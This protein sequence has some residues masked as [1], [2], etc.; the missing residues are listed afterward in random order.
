MTGERQAEKRNKNKKTNED[1]RR[2]EMKMKNNLLAG[3]ALMM[4]AFSFNEAQA[5]SCAVPPTCAQL[6]YVLKADD[7]KGFYMMRCPFALTDDNQVFCHHALKRE[8]VTGKILYGDGT[9]SKELISG[10]TPIG[11][12]FDETN[13]LAVALTDVKKDGS[14]G[15]EGMLWAGGKTRYDIPNLENCAMRGSGSTEFDLT[16][17][18]SCTPDGRANTDKILACGDACGGTPAATACNLYK[19]SG[20]SAAFCGQGKWFLPS[21]KEFSKIFE[22]KAVIDDTLTFLQEYGATKFSSS[23]WGSNERSESE[24]WWVY[25]IA[26]NTSLK[27]ATS[28]GN[29]RQVR[30]IVK[31]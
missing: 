3:A 18:I 12:V 31:Y 6:G 16:A 25:P 30:P 13:R 14:A 9:V 24:A 8:L 7:C 26:Y 29:L 19:P 4:A 1:K 28:T 15:S 17:L 10:K 20:C 22:T 5:T 23:Y 21:M 27:Y 11:V 2:K